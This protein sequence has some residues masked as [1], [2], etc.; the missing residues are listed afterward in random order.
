MIAVAAAEP[1]STPSPPVWLNVN[2]WK[3]RGRLPQTG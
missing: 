2:S 1:T 3:R